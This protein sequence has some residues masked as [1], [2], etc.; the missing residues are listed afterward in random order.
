MGPD[1]KELLATLSALVEAF[2]NSSLER[3]YTHILEFE[4][5]FQIL[6]PILSQKEAFERYKDSLRSFWIK[7]FLEPFSEDVFQYAFK[8]GTVHAE[9][10]VSPPLF[11]KALFRFWSLFRE[12]I[13]NRIEDQALQK[14][15]IQLAVKLLFYLVSVVLA[16]YFKRLDQDLEEAYAEI[17]RLNR[18]YVLLREINLLIFEE[19]VSSEKLFKEAC[20][21]LVRDGG[22][23]LA[24]IG[25]IE[26]KTK[27]VK[28]L[29]AAGKT[30]YLNDFYASIDPAIAEG[31]GPCGEALRT[32]RP[33]VVQDTEEDSRF[34]PW[35]ERARQYGLR[36]AVALPLVL[37]N[38]VK[39]VLL[40]YHP[41]PQYFTSKE[42]QLLL[43]ISRDLSLG[44]AHIEKS[45]EL[46]RVLFTDELTGLG[47]ERYLIDTL[48]HEFEVAKKQKQRLA[49]VRLDIDEFS[50][51]THSLGRAAGDE[52]LKE[53]GQRLVRLVGSRGTVV[54]SGADEFSCSYL[55]ENNSEIGSFMGRIKNALSLPVYT[56][57]SV[58]RVSASMGLAFF[59]EDASSPRGLLEAASVALRRAKKQ[60]PG[61]VAFYS[62]KEAREVLSRWRLTEELERACEQKEF[63]LF[64]QPRVDLF[65]RRISSF[66]ALLRWRHP[67]KGIISPGKFISVLEDTGL[68]TKVGRWVVKESALFL[69][70]LLPKHSEIS[71]SFNV[72]MKQFQDNHLLK[73]LEETLREVSIPPEWLEVEITESLF[74]EAGAQASE[75][76]KNIN[77]LGLKIAIDDFGTGYSSFA[78][79]KKIPAESLK[80]DYS[81]VKGIPEDR[82][83]ASVVMAI[84]AMARNL[85]KKIVAEGVERREQL[86]FLMGLGVD[87]VQGYYFARPMPGD[88]ALSFLESFNPD[89]FFR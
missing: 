56:A 79:L 34:I 71:I 14:S 73:V 42:A 89:R 1:E 36:S 55:F 26:P 52:V 61:G 84:V 57:E 74:F 19:K 32:G 13:W 28:P 59:P 76:L 50:L 43:E 48:E 72:S 39:G 5:G 70:K 11:L 44:W 77:N 60:A 63:V 58:I 23:A 78:Y 25:L 81:F 2:P 47:N 30:D 62:E 67:Q 15:L 31:R 69:K 9:K 20:K 83:D 22:F 86:A 10:G 68:I 3:F 8:I 51:L 35:R 41:K 49:L 40:L 64:F 66:E 37:G 24:W 7:F 65:N 4:E 38:E 88:Q 53:V 82:E 54:R 33:V 6:G 87:E 46:E 21:I 12:H 17:A 16:A 85:G 80:I 45:R 18:I 75:I 29:A 27:E